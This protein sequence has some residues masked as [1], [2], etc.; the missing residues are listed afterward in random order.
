M[1][2]S[3]STFALLALAIIASTALAAKSTELANAPS[4]V[5]VADA[6]RQAPSSDS[7]SGSGSDSSSGSGSGESSGKDQPNEDWGQVEEKVKAIQKNVATYFVPD[8]P[9]AQTVSPAVSQGSVQTMGGS[10][11][12][13]SPQQ[14]GSAALSQVLSQSLPA[15]AQSSV[16]SVVS[17]VLGSLSQSQA[18]GPD[19]SQSNNLRGVPSLAGSSPQQSVPIQSSV[20]SI[21]QSLQSLAGAPPAPPQ[22]PTGG[23]PPPPPGGV[24]P[25]PQS[26]GSIPAPPQPPAGGI[27]PP[28]GS[29]SSSYSSS[30]SIQSDANVPPPPPPPAPGQFPTP[31][32]FTSSSS[33]SADSLS[34]QS[35]PGSAGSAAGPSITTTTVAADGC[36]TKTTASANG[37]T[38]QKTCPPKGSAS[39]SSS[40]PGSVLSS[41]SNSLSSLSSSLGGSSSASSA[42][43]KPTG[44]A[45]IKFPELDGSHPNRIRMRT[46]SGQKV[47][48]HIGAI[49]EVDP[50]ALTPVGADD[51]LSAQVGGTR[52]GCSPNTLQLIRR[53][54]HLL[55][56]LRGS[57]NLAN[58]VLT[59]CAE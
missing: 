20:Q 37:A 45:T 17:A 34:S 14:S 16:G 10:V 50:N 22:P 3:R 44:C 54:Q 49:K 1:A 21:I 25:P 4:F 30:S 32:P 51:P 13:L 47:V 59:D 18:A 24:L 26:S 12:A 33:S 31:P 40:L 53:A 9:A 2:H 6:V 42:C 48:L 23:I 19:F 55:K 35:L 36:V 38:T 11:S 7:S 56:S 41:I 27:P 29:S 58:K 15:P 43:N 57:S 8:S 52:P 46:A 28:P 5:E 39:G